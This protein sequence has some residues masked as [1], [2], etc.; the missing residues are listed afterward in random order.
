MISFWTYLPIM[1][2]PAVL[3][4]HGPSID[5]IPSSSGLSTMLPLMQAYRCLWNQ[6]RSTCSILNSQRNNCRTCSPRTLTKEQKRQTARI[7]ELLDQKMTEIPHSKGDSEHSKEIKAHF[8]ELKD[9][10]GRI[11]K[12]RACGLICRSLIPSLAMTGGLMSL[13]FTVKIQR[14]RSTQ[15]SNRKAG[16]ARMGPSTT[17]Y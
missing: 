14:N 1:P 10:G 16:R 9:P 6:Q 2:A 3:R 13:P 12:P 11:T 4:Q 5:A 17:T 15:V 7:I 8:Q